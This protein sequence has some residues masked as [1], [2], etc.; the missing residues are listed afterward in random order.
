MIL[1][2]RTYHRLPDEARTVRTEVFMQEQG[3]I[4]EFDATDANAKH[5]VAFVDNVPIGTCRFF[6]DDGHD[7]GAGDSNQEITKSESSVTENTKQESINQESTNKESASQEAA[8]QGDVKEEA[9]NET[10][11]DKDA[12]II[13][14]KSDILAANQ[15][16]ETDEQHQEAQQQ[17]E[18]QQ[19]QDQ[20]QEKQDQQN[21]QKQEQQTQQQVPGEMSPLQMP[22]WQDLPSEE[23]SA[24]WHE[25]PEEDNGL[26]WRALPE[27]RG[28]NA[29]ETV[30][31]A[32]TLHV[33]DE[34]E[35]AGQGYIIGRVAVVKAYRGKNIGAHILR[36][37]AR[38]IKAIG[39]THI[40]LAAQVQ[41]RGFYETLGYVAYGN[42]FDDEGCPH[43]WMKK[44]LQ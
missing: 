18:P 19:N 5:I 15:D 17:Q 20:Q 21:E 34:I 13:F 12:T 36:D 44:S 37:A 9:V 8:A 6:E 14:K 41:A 7:H 22:S 43:I 28:D 10:L 30:H 26:E 31:V 39:G 4:N 25:S 38:E 16:G 32:E 27:N 2:F 29:A 3:F 23:W 35:P 1:E 40:R 11:N 42:E 33:V 24:E